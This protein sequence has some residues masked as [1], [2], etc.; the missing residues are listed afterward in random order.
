[1]RNSDSV[2]LIDCQMPNDEI[3]N[4]DNSGNHRQYNA[5]SENHPESLE[6]DGNNCYVAF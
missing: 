6:V 2:L 3:K 1:M 4:K 5:F